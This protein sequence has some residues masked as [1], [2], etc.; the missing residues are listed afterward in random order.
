MS[1]SIVAAVSAPSATVNDPVTSSVRPVT[2]TSSP[3]STSCT[4]YPAYEPSPTVHAPA[5]SAGS[6]A[7]PSPDGA[8]SVGSSAAA[9]LDQSAYRPGPNAT[10]A[11][12]ST[13]TPTP[14]PTSTFVLLR[15][16]APSDH[17]LRLRHLGDEAAARSVHPGPSTLRGRAVGPT[18]GRAAGRACGVRAD[19]R[20]GR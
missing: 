13:T 3:C 1:T 19:A 14:T 7:A 16:S 20:A 8:S 17:P 11:P 9:R 10:A 18:V 2:V 12:P 6:S 5:R 15:T 4:R